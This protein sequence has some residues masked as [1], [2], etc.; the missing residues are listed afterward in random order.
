MK[1]KLVKHNH[2]RNFYYRRKLIIALSVLFVFSMSVAI[3]VGVTIYNQ[4]RIQELRN[5]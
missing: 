1:D 3:P 5:H 2:K 4:V